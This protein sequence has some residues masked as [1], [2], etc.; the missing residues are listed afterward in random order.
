MDTSPEGPRRTRADACPGALQLHEASDGALAR[1]RLPGGMLTPEQLSVLATASRELSTGDLELTSRGNVQFR[2]VTDADDLAVRLADA[3]LLPSPTHERVRN[4]LASPLAGRVGD[5]PDVSDLV[6]RLD[7]ALRADPDLAELPGRIL[8]T[9]DDG[10]GDVSGLDADIGVHATG[11]DFALVVA[12]ADTGVR[13]PPEAAVET[14]IDV[15]RGF[16]RE[17][18]TQW[19]IAEIPGGV[20]AVVSHT[21]RV[22]SAEKIDFDVVGSAPVGWFDQAD[23][24]VALGAVLAHGLLPARTAEV[25][26]AVGA[27]VIV[28]PWRSIVLVDLTEGEAEAVVRVLAPM[29]LIFDANSP[30]ASATS[31]VGSPGCAKSRADVRADLERAVDDGE[32]VP[33]ERQHWVGCERACG[34]PRSTHVRVQAVGDGYERQSIGEVPLT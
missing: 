6:I 25:I 13:V 22:P 33:G 21:G 15:A 14:M 24:R 20:D 32:V 23:G 8:F 34:T 29:G 16:G 10:R 12:G 11:D 17:R 7:E 4:I 2:S 30:W 28:T 31:C 27:P 1:V 19:R 26:V 3:G 9:V 5:G 18:T